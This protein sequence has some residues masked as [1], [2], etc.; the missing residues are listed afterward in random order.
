MELEV[1]QEKYCL[2]RKN[3]Q[4]NPKNPE[5]SNIFAGREALKNQLKKRVTRARVSGAKLNTLLYGT[6]G[7]GKT[8]TL[9]YIQKLLKEKEIAGKSV[10]CYLF[11][12]PTVTKG[13]FVDFYEEIMKN[14]GDNFVFETIIKCYDELEKSLS[15]A[16]KDLKDK[17]DL[18]NERIK[19][20]DLTKIL[21]DKIRLVE[22]DDLIW[23]WLQGKPCSPA[24]K[25]ALGVTDDNSTPNNA[26]KTLEGF[27]KMYEK[28]NKEQRILVLLVDE[29][30]HLDD[31]KGEGR[32]ITNGFRMI[33]DQESL[34]FICGY[35]AASLENMP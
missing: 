11:P 34:G 5:D 1:F 25:K 31:I 8:H 16:G 15:L 13:N 3:F 10:D 12:Y 6:Y 20:R 30:E 23:K 24:E 7:G 32:D 18:I 29:L 33:C 26:I 22:N 14:L 28:G 21:M 17:I 2:G 35:Y 4:L 27:V 19:N 9:Y